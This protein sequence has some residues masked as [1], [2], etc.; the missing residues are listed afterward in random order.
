MS[1]EDGFL[2]LYRVMYFMGCC[3]DF[4]VNN[5][6]MLISI[7][8]YECYL[9]PASYVGGRHET[10]CLHQ[11]SATNMRLTSDSVPCLDHN[12]VPRRMHAVRIEGTLRYLYVRYLMYSS[13]NP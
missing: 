11:G 4:V 10:R 1:F 12:V 6:D 13:T 8:P 5:P 7:R 3:I 2:M 9:I